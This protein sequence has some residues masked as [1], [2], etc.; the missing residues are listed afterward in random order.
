MEQQA[1]D[2]TREQVLDAYVQAV[3]KPDGRQLADWIRR[4]PEHEHAL[5][6]FTLAWTVMEHLPAHLSVGEIEEEALVQQGME[7]VRTLLGRAGEST[8]TGS[9]SSPLEGII[10]EGKTK[11]RSVDQIVEDSELSIPLIFKLDRRLIRYQTIPLEAI[12]RVAGAVQR[13]V[14]SVARYLAGT[15]ELRAATHYRA[16]RKPRVQSQED[17]FDAVRKDRD[18]AD[19]VRAR[20][21]RLSPSSCDKESLS[22]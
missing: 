7:H 11:E 17:F 15:P 3:G 10:A 18:M 20:W 2:E 12:E 6:E 9:P 5:V 16:D 22:P 4:Y 21:L 19:D 1:R 13:D 14:V 8:V